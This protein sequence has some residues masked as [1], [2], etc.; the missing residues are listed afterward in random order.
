MMDAWRAAWP[1]PSPGPDHAA[2][3]APS[4]RFLK[5]FYRLRFIATGMSMLSA[6]LLPWLV[7]TATQRIAAA[8]MVMLIEASVRLLMSLYGGQLAHAIGGRRAFAASQA[9]CAAGFA[10]FA[11]VLIVYP[12]SVA[13]ALALVVAA[14]V[15]MQA[16]ITVGNVVT[17][18]CTVAFLQAGADEV[19]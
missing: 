16:G 6:V 14:L 5:P 10:L 15:F 4:S 13:G 18:A 3:S 8:G 17:E 11:A 1:G 7:Y 2:M 12:V 19:P 9:A